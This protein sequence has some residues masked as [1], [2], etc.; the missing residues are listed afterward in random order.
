MYIFRKSSPSRPYFKFRNSQSRNCFLWSKWSCIFITILNTM[1]QEKKEPSKTSPCIFNTYVASDVKIRLEKIEVGVPW[2]WSFVAWSGDLSNMQG[3]EEKWNKNG[4]ESQLYI[5]WS[6]DH[7][8]E[9]KCYCH[10]KCYF[11]EAIFVWVHFKHQIT[12]KVTLTFEE[13]GHDSS[14]CLCSQNIFLCLL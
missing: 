7:D 11:W 12:S 13:R 1:K 6:Y 9:W 8:L 3:K 2:K 10:Y 14:Y 4:N 5:G